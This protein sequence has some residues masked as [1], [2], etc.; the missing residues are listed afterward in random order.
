MLNFRNNMLQDV[1]AHM[2]PDPEAMERIASPLSTKSA[3]IRAL[4][5]AGF[6]RADIA[7]FLGI[8]YQHV[9]NILTQQAPKEPLPIATDSVPG[10]FAEGAAEWIVETARDNLEISADGS[11]RV[12]KTFLRAAGIEADDLVLARVVNGEIRLSGYKASLKRAQWIAQRFHKPDAS[13]VDDFIA[14][15]RAAGARGD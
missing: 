4:D 10:G 12:P 11:L 5:K 9:R 3:K 14:G 15:R 13:E 2:R 6:A 8:K 1:E 7:R